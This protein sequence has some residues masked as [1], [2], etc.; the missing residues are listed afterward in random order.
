MLEKPNRKRERAK[1]RRE[2]DQRRSDCRE[3]VFKLDH[4]RC[5]YPGCKNFDC[6]WA[7]LIGREANRT[8]LDTPENTLTLCMEH[9]QWADDGHTFT[10]G[11]VKTRMTGR[12][13]KLFILSKY[14]NSPRWRWTK[15]YEELKRR[16]E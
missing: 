14:L 3:A 15:A 16:E 6:T 13:I 9:H 4:C 10:N 11:G 8:D 1:R 5:L 7:H 12:Q 2:I